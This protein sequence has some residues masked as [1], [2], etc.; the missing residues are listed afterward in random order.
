MKRPIFRYW[1][2]FI[3]LSSRKIKKISDSLR[4]I[5]NFGNG[6]NGPEILLH[7]SF[8]VDPDKCKENIDLLL[9][10]IQE[11]NPQPA[12]DAC[13]LPVVQ[14]AAQAFDSC[15]R[16][17]KLFLFHSSLP[18][19]AAPGKLQNRDDRKLIAT[20]KEKFLFQA[21]DKIY[22]KVGKDLY[23]DVASIQ[24]ALLYTS[25]ERRL[26]IHNLQ[27]GVI[28]QLADVYKVAE[29]DA[30]MNFFSKLAVRSCRDTSPQKLKE[31]IIQR[32]PIATYRKHCADPSSIGQ[33]ILP[34]RLKVMPA[35]MN[36]LLCNDDIFPHHE[37]NTDD[38]AYLRQKI[39]QMNVRAS[40]AYFYACVYP[41]LNTALDPALPK[42]SLRCS[43]E[44]FKQEQVYVIENGLQLYIWVGENVTPNGV[45][46]I[47]EVNSSRHSFKARNRAKTSK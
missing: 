41:I 33:L 27:L 3:M 20:D 21:A 10:Q 34:E 16:A 44:R 30:M 39:L 13:F 15:Q 9:G 1:E 25:V 11:L 8:V 14:V 24:V 18:T 22:E 29:T 45:Q 7:C 6:V 46:S 31:G 32:F 5:L 28:S 37:T 17:G 4:R 43:I 23:V 12:P 35:Y 19:V 40:C 38:W 42:L 2:N 26:R 47:W 36:S